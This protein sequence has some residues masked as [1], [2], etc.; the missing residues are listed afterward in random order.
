[1]RKEN[2]TFSIGYWMGSAV[3]TFAILCAEVIARLTKT[4]QYYHTNAIYI[5]LGVLI[6]SLLIAFLCKKYVKEE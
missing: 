6:F 5:Y 2:K 1:M 3:G 4:T